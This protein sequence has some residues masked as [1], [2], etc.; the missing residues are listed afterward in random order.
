[1]T[2]DPALGRL[3]GTGKEAD[4]FEY[5][6]Q[7]IKLYKAAAPKRSAFREAAH[8]ALVESLGLP[9]PSVHGVNRFGDRWGVV[10]SRA[11]GQSFAEAVRHQPEALPSYIQAMAKL[12]YHVHQQQAIQFASVK[13]RL[14]ANIQQTDAL[15]DSHKNALLDRLSALPEGD[16][17]CHGDFHPL[18]II[19][20]IGNEVLIDWP[21]A[22]KG[23][24]TADVCRSYVLMKKVAPELA[25]SY[26][27]VYAQNSGESRDKILSWLPFVA[28]ARLAEG[29]PDETDGLLKMAGLRRQ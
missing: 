13:V 7:V 18:N 19:G 21:N 23:E 27:D 5:G 9:V 4:V 24:P 20:S 25:D 26:I 16:R 29:V 11:Q 8:L 3:L 14:A 28:A 12:Q 15:D 22:S 1:M 17:L 2:N 10:M 6:T